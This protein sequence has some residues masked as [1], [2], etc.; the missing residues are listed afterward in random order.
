MR[1]PL[2][3]VPDNS[4]GTLRNRPLI[5]CECAPNTRNREDTHLE[6]IEINKSDASPERKTD[7]GRPPK[8]MMWQYMW[9]R[10]INWWQLNRCK[11]WKALRIRTRQ[12]T[13]LGSLTTHTSGTEKPQLGSCFS[14]CRPVC[15]ISG[16]SKYNREPALHKSTSKVMAY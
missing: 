11:Q 12:G 15:R 5:L 6:V 8:E 9:C 16:E 13:S 14:M 7:R 4:W 10:Q 1:Y 3:P 2:T